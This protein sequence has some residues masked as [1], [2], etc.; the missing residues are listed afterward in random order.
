MPRV[1]EVK[2][3]ANLFRILNAG[4]EECLPKRWSNWFSV[5]MAMIS[6]GYQIRVRGGGEFRRAGV[7]DLRLR[8]WELSQEARQSPEHLSKPIS[9][10]SILALINKEGFVFHA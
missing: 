8:A 2:C 6:T 1:K 7:A 9:R 4:T 10:T 5:L 3:L